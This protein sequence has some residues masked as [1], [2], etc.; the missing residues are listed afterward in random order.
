MPRNSKTP[1]AKV[2]GRDPS[3]IIRPILGV[4]LLLDL[5][6]AGLVL[7]P[8]GGSA[9]SLERELV[10]L[11]TQMSQKRE[12]LQQ[13][14]EHAE[15]VQKGRGEGD[16]FLGDYF[17]ERRT[18]S[19]TL[20]S[21]LTDFAKQAQIKERDQVHSTE[22]VEG[23]DS[24]AMMTITADYEGT[25]ANLMRFVREI[26]RSPRLLIIESLNAAPQQG[27][28]TLTVSMKINAFV[29]GEGNDAPPAASAA[30]AQ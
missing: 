16:K 19:S 9:E 8:P 26:D 21:E 22:L 24:L 7:Y 27:S 11:Q 28:N 14:R 18:V 3:R 25:Y 10:S 30:G 29:Q 23:S 15:A 13:T 4:L 20:L 1:A 2:N 6:A 5:V 17:L 12:L